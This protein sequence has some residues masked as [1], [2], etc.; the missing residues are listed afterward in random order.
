V[1][2]DNRQSLPIKDTT[3]PRTLAVFNTWSARR[4]PKRVSS[5]S[6]MPPSSASSCRWV[7]VPRSSAARRRRPIACCCKSMPCAILLLLLV[8]ES[9]CLR[10]I[11]HL[12]VLRCQAPTASVRLLDLPSEPSLEMLFLYCLPHPPPLTPLLINNYSAPHSHCAARSPSSQ[13]T[14]ALIANPHGGSNTTHNTHRL[15]VGILGR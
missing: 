10:T 6:L 7:A 14:L 8:R 13:A 2:R 3:W 15:F 12:Y 9:S 5:K 1:R 11:A 4:L